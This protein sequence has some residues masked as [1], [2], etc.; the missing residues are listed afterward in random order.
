[1]AR[2]T[3][4]PT[5]DPLPL[6]GEKFVILLRHGIAQE[7][8]GKPD[9]ERSLTATGHQRMKKIGRTLSQIFPGVD[10]IFSSPLRRC[11]ETAEWVSRGY[12]RAV[13]VTESAALAP[14]AAPADARTLILTSETKRLI[15][16]GHEPGLSALMLLMTNMQATEGIELKKGGCYGLRVQRDGKAS[17]EWMLPPRFLRRER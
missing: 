12:E 7:K 9:E 17:V 5:D 2:K 6:D 4:V 1:M 3:P 8:E 13:V 15:C 10:A 16:V 11:T 14:A